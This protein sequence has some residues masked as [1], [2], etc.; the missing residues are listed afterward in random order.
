MDD[1]EYIII[2]STKVLGFGDG[3]GFSKLPGVIPALLVK[4][5]LNKPCDETHLSQIV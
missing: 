4:G 2:A 1:T 5:F 3:N